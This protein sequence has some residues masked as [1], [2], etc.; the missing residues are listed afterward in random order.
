LA[1]A[2]MILRRRGAEIDWPR[3]LVDAAAESRLLAVSDALGQLRSVF[4][5]DNVPVPAQV[6]AH[7]S[8][9]A[10]TRRERFEHRVAA[11]PRLFG[12]G[13]LVQRIVDYRRW[14]RSGRG[15]PARQAGFAGYLRLNWGLASLRQ[16]PAQVIRRGWRTARDD[17]ERL[18]GRGSDSSRASSGA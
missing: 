3:L 11:G 12:V 18:L 4:G 6:V 9:R 10:W 16:V 13:Y 7:L 15:S 17:V 5:G 2:L 1:D 14:R 8:D